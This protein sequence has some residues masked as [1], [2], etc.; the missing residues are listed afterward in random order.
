MH[1]CFSEHWVKLFS[2]LLLLLHLFTLTLSSRKARPALSDCDSKRRAQ[3]YLTNKPPLSLSL[4]L[5]L[6]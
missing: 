1:P 4:S 3:V 2:V 5:F 6:Y